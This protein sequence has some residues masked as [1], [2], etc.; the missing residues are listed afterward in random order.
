MEPD[1]DF[2]QTGFELTPVPLPAA[3]QSGQQELFSDD[4]SQPDTADREPVFW[5]ASSSQTFP[6][7]DFVQA[8]APESNLNSP[9]DA[10]TSGGL[11]PDMIANVEIP[12]GR[13]KLFNALA[14]CQW[15]LPHAE[16]EVVLAPIYLLG[17]MGRPIS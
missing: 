15:R 4:C 9:I 6:A 12:F 16:R 11:S 1:A 8:D 2:D 7:D 14:V 13:L 17:T 10:E 5:S 3:D